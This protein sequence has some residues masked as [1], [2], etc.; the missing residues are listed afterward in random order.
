LKLILKPL[1]LIFY[2][3]DLGTED[4]KTI[5][6]TTKGFVIKILESEKDNVGLLE[7]EFEHVRQF[8]CLGWFHMLFMWIPAYKAWTERRALKK[9]LNSK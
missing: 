5:Y 7:H 8:W 1:C 4:G 6:G 9:Q 2:K 3:P